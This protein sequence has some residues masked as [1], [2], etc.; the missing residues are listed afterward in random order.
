MGTVDA[1]RTVVAC[2]LEGASFVLRRV[3]DRVD[4]DEDRGRQRRSRALSYALAGVKD[5]D[6]DEFPLEG[7]ETEKF[8]TDPKCNYWGS[9]CTHW[10][11]G[12]EVCC[13]CGTSYEPL[14]LAATIH[15]TDTE[16]V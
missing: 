5:A 2:Y 12:A 8:P 6:P 3:V 16:T 14:D 9:C 4:P 1:L 15:E 11:D 10:E 7:E 13:E